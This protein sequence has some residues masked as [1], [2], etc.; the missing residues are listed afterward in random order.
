M[1][2]KLKTKIYVSKTILDT[3]EDRIMKLE[4]SMKSLLTTQNR[5]I[6]RY[7]VEKRN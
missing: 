4:D 6:K 1:V 3:A 7:Q 2:L 5:Q